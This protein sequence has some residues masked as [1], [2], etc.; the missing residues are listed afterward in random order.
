MYIVFIDHVQRKSESNFAALKN[1]SIGSRQ[2]RTYIELG[3]SGEMRRLTYVLA[4]QVE[5]EGGGE[6]AAKIKLLSIRSPPTDAS[7]RGSLK[8]CNFLRRIKSKQERN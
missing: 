2:V 4:W 7:F 6:R 8:K 1:P 3:S 5:R